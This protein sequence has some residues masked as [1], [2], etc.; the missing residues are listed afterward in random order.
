M[1]KPVPDRKETNTLMKALLEG[2]K[3]SPKAARLTGPA[4]ARLL[5]GLVHVGALDQG[6]TAD[7]ALEAAASPALGGVPIEINVRFQ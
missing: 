3:R 2:A 7:K 1:I 6:Y 5:R 4:A